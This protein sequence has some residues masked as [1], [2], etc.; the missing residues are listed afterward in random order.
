MRAFSAPAGRSLVWLAAA[1]T[2]LFAPAACTP[3]RLTSPHAG[4][5]HASADVVPAGQP[6]LMVVELMGDPKAVADAGGEWIKLYNPGPVDVDL[7]NFRIQSGVGNNVYTGSGSVESHT[8]ASSIAVP[9]GS[10]VV[11]GNNTSTSVNGGVNEAYSYG[12]SITL[13]N[14]NT[15]WVTIK[16]STGMLL[17]SV[18]YSTSTISGTTRTVVSPSM[19]IKTGISR[20]V[21]DPAQDRTVMA[22]SN[23]Q[24]APVD[25]T[26]GTSAT[27]DRGMPNSCNYTY[28]VSS[29]PIGPI[30][31]MTLSPAH[32]SLNVNAT[33]SLTAAAIDDNNNVITSDPTHFTWT[34]SND[35]VATVSD[36]GVVTGIVSSPQPVT[37]TATSTD[38]AGLSATASIT[39]TAAPSKISVSSRTVP[40]PI[41]YQTQL[42]ASGT[43]LSGTSISG[44]TMTWSS[45]DDNVVT[46]DSHGV[47]SAAGAGSAKIRATAA[48]GSFGETTITT[49]TQ[50][51]S[52]SARAGHNIELGLP[53]DADASDDV[54]ITRK[55][56]T[57]SWNPQRGDPNWVSWDL[58]ASHI[59]ST[60]RCNCFSA[61]TALARLGYGSKM[62][63]TA[64]YI[65]GGQWD[66]GHMES[67]ADQTTT[68]T[69]NGATF[70][71][72]NMLPQRHD[73]NAGPWEKL[74]IALRDSAKAGREVYQ[75]AGGV[76]TNGSGLGTLNN[77]GKIA[78]PDSTWKIAVIMPAGSGLTSVTSPQS[79]T[80]IAVNMPNV[81][82]IAT[83]GWQMYQTTVD[84]IQHSTGYDFL[85]AIPEAIQCRLE[86]RNCA[87]VS[88]FSVS[89][90]AKEGSSVS[91][92]ASA[93]SDADGD[94][95]TYSWNFGDGS[96]AT[97]AQ[98]SH[99]YAVAGTYGITLTVTDS[100][101]GTGSVTQSLTVANVAPVVSPIS[102]AALLTG[103]SYA[104]AGSFTDPGADH[105]SATVDYGDGSGA[106]SLS[107]SGFTFQ[108]AHTYATGGNFTVTVSVS[109]GH[110]GTGTQS[111]L[112]A[113]QD[114]SQGIQTLS[115]MITGLT[116]E[117][118]NGQINS[119]HV[120]LRG[121]FDALGTGNA[122]TASNVLGAFINE[123]NAMAQSGRLS[124]TSA[125]SLTHY[126]QRIITS[127]GQ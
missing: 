82:G 59:G 126:A 89:G 17:D 40:L 32:T 104:S 24:D 60:D 125:S 71:L 106:Q 97:G 26:F 53:T 74:E 70:F 36:S 47:V 41:G 79:V 9:V 18:A 11:L 45:A 20:L 35:D 39:V 65:A 114:P 84:R 116:G 55:Q 37:I 121:A 42:F 120:K 90:T 110:G 31:H 15:D 21:I 85:S 50:F 52:S 27:P 19:T 119:F 111:A 38:V 113:V 54:I 77:A 100:K 96:S 122:N 49:E 86:T 33:L 5:P 83:N 124:S 68:D 98:T 88:D 23:W 8:I 29:G 30:T 28:R 115:N 95:I 73:L 94:A 63:T 22:G 1:G 108:L 118:N 101:G 78:I 81:V 6:R 123:V 7:Q 105:W 62:Y 3:D 51:F 46:V 4:A 93:S 57:I 76:F 112:V 64:D 102:G 44:Q 107:L 10:C 75:I 2:L 67:S 72:T 92:D 66:R 127:M 12:T 103:E 25:S 34:T 43:D 109:D 61:D 56:Y 13:G 69:E 117:I 87:P 80:V 91:F 14:N 16:S 58:S 48:D 99:T